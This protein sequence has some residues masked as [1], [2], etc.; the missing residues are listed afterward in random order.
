M[1]SDYLEVVKNSTVCLKSL[2]PKTTKAT[3]GAL[4]MHQYLP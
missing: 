1:M 2:I 3:V 4:C